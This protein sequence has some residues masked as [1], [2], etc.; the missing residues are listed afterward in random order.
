V[1]FWQKIGLSDS[2]SR[3]SIPASRKSI[4]ILIIELI[5]LKAQQY[6]VKIQ[7]DVSVQITSADI[8]GAGPALEGSVPEKAS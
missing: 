8:S 3:T 1:H 5:K 4:L 6:D 7:R 2:D